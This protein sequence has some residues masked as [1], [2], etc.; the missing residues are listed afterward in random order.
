[1]VKNGVIDIDNLLKMR[2]L[3]RDVKRSRPNNIDKHRDLVV[4]KEYQEII[5][6]M[7][8]D[9]ISKYRVREWENRS[10]FEKEGFKVEGH[11]DP[12]YVSIPE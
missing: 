1:M 9:P 5:S 3:R 2:I 10:R 12:V 6:A 11:G 7:W 8:E 4:E